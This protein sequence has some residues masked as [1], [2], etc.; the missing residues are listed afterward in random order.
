[1]K[2]VK[3][4]LDENGIKFKEKGADY[5]VSCL[6]P[7]HDD[8]HPSLHIDTL[9][10]KYNCWSCG[11]HGNVFKLFNEEPP[12]IQSALTELLRTIDEMLSNTEGLEIPE[13]AFMYDEEFRGISASTLQSFEAFTHSDY[14]GRIC[15]P[16][17]NRLTNKI[18][19]IIAR[20][21]KSSVSPK[22]LVYP[23]GLSVP[24]F[25]LVESDVVIL[26]E[27]IFDMLNCH[28]KGYTN[29]ACCFGTKN[30]TN[31]NMKDKLNDFIIVGAKKFVLLLDNDQAGN[32]AAKLL[33]SQMNKNGFL[34]YIG[35]GYLPDGKDP[36]EL[37]ASELESVMYNITN[38]LI[39]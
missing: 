23:M 19:N 18:T 14:P 33:A 39:N 34:T 9:T 11:F 12:V 15:I 28:D 13:S 5:I 26:V 38:H 16:L 8:L 30:L 37:S 36:G 27:G 32:S 29:V 2:T 4:I 24:V 21:F 17:R 6:N 31:H 3:A 25:P 1:M 35:N 10:G 22:Y 20:S 7:E